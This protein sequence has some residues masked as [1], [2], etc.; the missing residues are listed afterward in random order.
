MANNALEMAGSGLSLVTTYDGLPDHWNTKPPLLIWLMAVSIRLL[1]P[2]ELAVRLPSVLAAFATVSIMFI[3]CA[4]RLR[5]PAAGFLA[6]AALFSMPGYVTYHAARS[7]EYDSLLTFWTTSY[8]L[9]GYLFLHGQPKR[10][11]IWLGVFATAVT[12]AFLTKTVQGLIF[13]PT[14]FVY[15][16][17]K[18]QM[19]TLLRTPAVFVYGFLVIAVCAGYY[20]LREQIDPGYF[21]SV[22]ENDLLGRFATVKGNHWGSPFFYIQDVNAFPWLIPGLFAAGWLAWRATGEARHQAGYVG[23]AALFYLL[24]ISL[25]R[26]KLFW[27]AM[28]LLPLV[29]LMVA[30]GLVQAGARLAPL[31]R[32][33]RRARDAAVVALCIVVGCAIIIVNRRWVENRYAEVTKGLTERYGLFLRSNSFRDAGINEAVVVAPGSPCGIFDYYIAPIK[34]YVD[35]LNS[36]G[37]RIQV[38]PPSDDMDLG[39][40]HVVAC[41]EIAARMISAKQISRPVASDDFCGL[42]RLTD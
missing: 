42:Y 25:S 5:K 37:A 36:Q 27:Y 20:I 10:R 15:A 21:S 3:F 29:S 33:T 28:P 14:L 38:Q 9:A 11:G 34:F 6:A 22:L 13:L 35:A 18:G 17:L 23:L 19:P 16:A 24:G 2:T 26:T 8:L 7:G 41:G 30:L 40:R 32:M 1:G 12:F 31:M 4:W 39:A